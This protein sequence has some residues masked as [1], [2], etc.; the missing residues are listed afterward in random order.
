MQR[1]SKEPDAQ[2]DEEEQ[3]GAEKPDLELACHWVDWDTLFRVK[4]S[5]ETR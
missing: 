2:R 5:S 3:E 1:R 4:V